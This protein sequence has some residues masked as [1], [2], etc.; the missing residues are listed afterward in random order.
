MKRRLTIG[1]IRAWFFLL[2]ALCMVILILIA[3]F[4]WEDVRT[5]VAR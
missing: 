2:V 5:S 3:L 4:A 1:R